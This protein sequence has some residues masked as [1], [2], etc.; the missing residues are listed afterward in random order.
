M[1][2]LR[3][4]SICHP[5]QPPAPPP[6]LRPPAAAAAAPPPSPSPLGQRAREP[7]ALGPTEPK[8]KHGLAWITRLFVIAWQEPELDAGSVIN[9]PAAAEIRLSRPINSKVS[10]RDESA[11]VTYAR[12]CLRFRRR[13]NA[14][15]IEVGLL[16]ESV[17]IL[18][19][20]WP[21][22]ESA[23]E[24]RGA[25]L[26]SN[27]LTE[28]CNRKNGSRAVFAQREN[29]RTFSKHRAI[30]QK[31]TIREPGRQMSQPLRP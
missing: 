10:I 6:P 15:L 30:P 4:G 16:R 22:L 29:P 8:P 2:A 12:A 23:V 13:E 5:L 26:P 17:G 25:S 21:S 31:T 9:R 18:E 11:R 27:I 1:L 28:C 20:F 14:V 7:L 19:R 24:V 3:D